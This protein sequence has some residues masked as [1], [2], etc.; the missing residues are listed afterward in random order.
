M[1]DACHEIAP[2]LAAWAEDPD[3]ARADSPAAR[4][5]AVCAACQQ[6]LRVQREVHGLL[7]ARAASLTGQA[8][9]ALRARIEAT[10]VRP[11]RRPGGWRLPVAATLLVALAGM[12]GYG[13]TSASP[14]VLAAQLALDHVKCRRLTG[15]A[16]VPDERVR[17]WAHAQP[18]APRLPAS[19][20]VHGASLVGVRR[21]LYGHGMV[22]H[23]LYDIEGHTVSVF[24]MPRQEA[25]GSPQRLDVLGQYTEVWAD[26]RRSMAVVGD[27]PAPTM[28][29]LARALRTA[30]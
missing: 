7:R 4:H 13:L 10:R 17:A 9:S 3:A 1:K 21:C 24:V 25:G 30:E 27:A 18:W 5:L 11:S 26:G 14:T 23:L 19:R 15:H 16:T 8:P 20:P 28:H 29:L 12:A 22:A 6:S 2:V